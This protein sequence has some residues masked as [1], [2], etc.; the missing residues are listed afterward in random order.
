MKIII[1]IFFVSCSKPE[2][3]Q[4]KLTSNQKL[5]Y[6]Q[7]TVEFK[8]YM[9]IC[10]GEIGYSWRYCFEM[11][12]ENNKLYSKCNTTSTGSIVTGTAIGT[13]VGGAVNKAMGIK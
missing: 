8:A 6:E 7:G 2:P 12:S 3:K 13:V 5:A 4:L 11:Y 9:D 10:L 1:L